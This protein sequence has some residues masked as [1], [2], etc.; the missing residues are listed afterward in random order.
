MK[1]REAHGVRAV[2]RRFST[3][4]DKTVTGKTRIRTIR[5]RCYVFLLLGGEG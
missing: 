1:P 5:Q 2:Y 3:G 4:R